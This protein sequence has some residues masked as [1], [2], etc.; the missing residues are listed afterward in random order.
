MQIVS[1][2]LFLISIQIKNIENLKFKFFKFSKFNSSFSIQYLISNFSTRTNNDCLYY[3]DM[4]MLCSTCLYSQ[5]KACFLFNKL[6][7]DCDLTYSSQSDVYVK[8]PRSCKQI[9]SFNKKASN[10]LYNIGTP[11]GQI[12]VF[13]EFELDSEGFTFLPR[14]SLSIAKSSFLKD[15]YLNQSIFLTKYLVL[16]QV[17][18]PFIFIQQLDR[19]S[20]QPITISINK[21]ELT[22]LSGFIYFKVS[23]V[24]ESG[25]CQPTNLTNGSGFKANGNLFTYNEINGQKNRTFFF[26]QILNAYNSSLPC[27]FLGTFNQVIQFGKT[28]NSNS[29]MPLSYF[30]TTEINMAGTSRFLSNCYNYKIAYAFSIGLK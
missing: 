22:Y 2:I 29:N 24:N 4:N 7:Y 21:G 16:N 26:Y 1:I 10:G 30:Y 27:R 8:Y 12:Q 20:D 11:N 28:A 9:K 23:F 13:C 5:D 19:C 25:S 6:A 18:Q 17:N 14:D 15:I 3:C